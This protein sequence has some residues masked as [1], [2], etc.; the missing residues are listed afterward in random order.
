ME[1][2]DREHEVVTGVWGEDIPRNLR[3][4]GHEQLVAMHDRISRAVQTAYVDDD[5]ESLAVLLPIERKLVTVLHD[6]L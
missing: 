6:R 1:L 2:T 5:E 3:E 4:V